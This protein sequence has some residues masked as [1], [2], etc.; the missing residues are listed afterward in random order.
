MDILEAVIGIGP[1]LFYG[2]G[3]AA[4][5]L[6]FHEIKPESPG[7]DTVYRCLSRIQNG[8]AQNELLREHV[9]NIHH[10]LLGEP[11]GRR[12]F[13]AVTIIV[14]AVGTIA[15]AGPRESGQ[16]PRDLVLAITLG[17]RALSPWLDGASVLR[18]GRSPVALLIAGAGAADA[19][20]AFVAKLVAEDA[21]AGAW[22][23]VIL[24]VAIVATVVIL[25]VIS[26]TTALQRSAATRV[27]P[28]V[29]VIQ[30]AVPI[31]LAPLVGGE[32]WSQTPLGGAVL[33]VAVAALA[34]GVGLL[35]SS[36]AVADVIAEQPKDEG[37]AQQAGAGPTREAG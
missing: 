12:D 35:G 3:L 32:G 9:E 22:A 10:W 36:P 11:V 4:C 1:K 7:K 21:S 20:A 28:V 26:E 31:V 29:L 16:V 24:W 13:L 30:I 34:V 23:S 17:A 6:V 2:T 14:A 33:V 25:G 15:W 18:A 27:A 8:Q 5:I 37:E 19:L